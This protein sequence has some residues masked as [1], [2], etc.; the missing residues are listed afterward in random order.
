MLPHERAHS[1]PVGPIRMLARPAS[2]HMT[3]LIVPGNVCP[4]APADTPASA[5][6]TASPDF[7]NIEREGR[8][9]GPAGP[10]PLRLFA[11]RHQVRGGGPR[12]HDPHAA[13]LRVV[14][15]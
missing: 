8:R 1:A 12:V 10:R 3:S 2:A 5:S 9:A 7:I 4:A 13:L 15:N 14:R 6:R 11:W